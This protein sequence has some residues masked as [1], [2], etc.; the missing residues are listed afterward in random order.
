LIEELLL[1]KSKYIDKE[2]SA[3]ELFYDL[4]GDSILF[5]KGSKEWES[6]RKAL[7]VAF[8]K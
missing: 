6:R 4:L 3:Y 1:T 7:S 2:K 5:I 8:F